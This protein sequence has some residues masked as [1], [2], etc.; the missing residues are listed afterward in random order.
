[1]NPTGYGP[2][3]A[4]LYFNGDESKFELCLAWWNEHHQGH[5]TNNFAEVTVRLYKDVVLCR[6]KAY[7]AVSLIDF[8]V[9]IMETY[10]RSRLQDLANGR[11]S[12][13]RLLLDKLH[14]KASYLIS[15]DRVT[16][17]EDGRYGVQDSDGTEL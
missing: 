10:Y 5:H 2:S 12:G 3:R 11:V 4:R 15:C 8:T 17:Y 14:R 7:N 13:Q 1:M 6:A 9:Q 16:D